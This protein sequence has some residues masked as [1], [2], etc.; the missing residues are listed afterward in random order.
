MYEDVANPDELVLQPTNEEIARFAGVS[1]KILNSSDVTLKDVL[2]L[3]P[4]EFEELI[5]DIWMKFG[6]EVELTKR[7][8][9][10]GIRHRRSQ[11]KGG[12]R[13]LLD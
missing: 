1:E 9:D 10:G 3:D 4:R 11:E 2:A 7:T 12:E 5:R 13:P 8:R 6:Y